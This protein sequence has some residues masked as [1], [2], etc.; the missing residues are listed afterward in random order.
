M[1]THFL[2]FALV[3]VLWTGA[4]CAQSMEDLAASGEAQFKKGD[5][6]R[7]IDDLSRQQRPAVNEHRRGSICSALALT[8]R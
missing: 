1:R 2:G 6:R 5:Y 7:A 4:A 8:R 3:A